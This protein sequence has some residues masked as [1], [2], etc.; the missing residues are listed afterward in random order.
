MEARK[1]G[2]A[3]VGAEELKESPKVPEI[4]GQGIESPT[5]LTSGPSAPDGLASDC[6]LHC[7]DA[8]PIHFGPCTATLPAE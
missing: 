4:T 8:I 6:R 2:F 7:P 5:C 1:G 3:V